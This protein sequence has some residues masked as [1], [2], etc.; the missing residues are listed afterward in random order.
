MFSM[1]NKWLAINSLLAIKTFQNIN[2]KKKI[3]L[4]IN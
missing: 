1:Q 4:A 3:E 2:K